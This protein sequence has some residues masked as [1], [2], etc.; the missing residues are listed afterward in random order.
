MSERDHISERVLRRGEF[1]FVVRLCRFNLFD[2]T[3]TRIGIDRFRY[4][5]WM[6]RL[7]NRTESK[8]KRFDA[9]FDS[10]AM[11]RRL[12]CG[13]ARVRYPARS[14]TYDNAM[15]SLVSFESVSSD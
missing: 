1:S 15:C 2:L 11:R 6:T 8:R 12:R 3:E 9:C 13:R 4:A 14:S 7:Q 5:V 10:S